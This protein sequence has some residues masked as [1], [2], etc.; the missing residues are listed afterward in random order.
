MMLHLSIWLM[1]PTSFNLGSSFSHSLSD[2][3]S[4]SLSI[5]HTQS[6]LNEAEVKQVQD[7]ADKTNTA[8]ENGSYELSTKLWGE[9]QGLA[10]RVRQQNYVASSCAVHDI[11]LASFPGHSHVFIVTRMP[12][13]G[14]LACVEKDLGDWGRG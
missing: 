10:V 12:K 8:L 4:L 2:S 13:R 5:N 6:L 14:R 7:L 3:L 1:F 9:T 11:I